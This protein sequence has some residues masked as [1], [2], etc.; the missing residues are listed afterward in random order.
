MWDASSITH[1]VQAKALLER[2][3]ETVSRS[4]ARRRAARQESSAPKEEHSAGAPPVRAEAQLAEADAS[5]RRELDGGTCP[6]A[7]GNYL[8]K[9]CGTVL[10][11]I[12]FKPEVRIEA[13]RIREIMHKPVVSCRPGD[14]LSAAAQAM[15][16][17]DC[18]CIPVA[19]EDGRLVGII[20]DRDICMATY[21]K[22]R[23]PQ[24]ISVA[25]VMAKR[26]TSCQA[27]ESA[28]VAE[29]K[30]RDKQIRRVPIV[31]DDNRLIGM[32]SQSDLARN[33][34]SAPRRN[35]IEKDFIH[36]MAAI[37]Q[38]RL[39]AIEMSPPSKPQTRGSE[40]P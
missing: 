12:S 16:E 15:W 32:L 29:G 31:D 2:K 4:R 30:M 25:D 36:T 26:V 37:S 34:A 21:T 33:A 14:T 8:P 10:L 23:A 18:G 13:M 11:G 28:D 7:G 19:G 20:T 27:D 9:S 38:P 22:S 40:R 17:H 3:K 5:S 1:L 24:T 6:G 35:T 39:R